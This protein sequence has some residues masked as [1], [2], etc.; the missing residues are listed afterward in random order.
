[1]NLPNLTNAELTKQVLTCISSHLSSR[2][3][4]KGVKYEVEIGPENY[5]NLVLFTPTRIKVFPNRYRRCKRDKVTIIS[6]VF[7]EHF[8]DLLI[9]T[10]DGFN[11]YVD[12]SKL[13]RGVYEYQPSIDNKRRRWIRKQ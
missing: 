2:G 3:D 4:C 10:D 9:E 7:K 8:P 11:T 6:H 5:Q 12:T 1:M 13:V